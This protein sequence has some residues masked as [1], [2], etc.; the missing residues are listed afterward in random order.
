MCLDACKNPVQKVLALA[1]LRTGKL[2]F[3]SCTPAEGCGLSGRKKMAS[4]RLTSSRLPGGISFSHSTTLLLLLRPHPH[5][6]PTSLAQP[7]GVKWEES[8][9]Q[10]MGSRGG[11]LTIGPLPHTGRAFSPRLSTRDNLSTRATSGSQLCSK[12]QQATPPIRASVSPSA[13]WP[14]S[15]KLPNPRTFTRT[16][17]KAQSDVHVVTSLL[18]PPS[19]GGRPSSPHEARLGIQV[20]ATGSALHRKLARPLT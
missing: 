19:S 1:H 2:R 11:V 3:G 5:P 14:H 15:P 13:R 20:R 9:C 10:F 16:F 8:A 4:R 7:K 17:C 6:H 18:T 12:P